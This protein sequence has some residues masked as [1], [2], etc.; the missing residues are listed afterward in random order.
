MEGKHTKSMLQGI[1][2]HL[3]CRD[4]FFLHFNYSSSLL[5]TY[6]LNIV[7]TSIHCPEMYTVNIV[8]ISLALVYMTVFKYLN[9]NTLSDS[10]NKVNNNHIVDYRKYNVL[11]KYFM[12][13]TEHIGVLPLQYDKFVDAL[14]LAEKFLNFSI[15]TGRLPHYTANKSYKNAYTDHMSMQVYSENYYKFEQLLSSATNDTR[16]NSTTKIEDED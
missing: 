15:L 3:R 13:F 4:V 11:N 9:F 1:V 8:L 14:R 5:Y 6:C 16:N 2:E 7:D 12:A 10:V